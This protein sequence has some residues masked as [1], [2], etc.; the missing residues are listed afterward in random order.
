MMG[1]WLYVG[2]FV[3]CLWVY[4]YGYCLFCIDIDY[5]C[6][7]LYGDGVLYWGVFI[8][9]GGGWMGNVNGYV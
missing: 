6:V 2:E 3:V 9:F 5:W 1:D 8:R 7:Y 4:L